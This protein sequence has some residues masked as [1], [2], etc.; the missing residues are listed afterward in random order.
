MNRLNDMLN[1][2]HNQR[3]LEEARKERLAQEARR[4]SRPRRWFRLR[5]KQS[6]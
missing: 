1:A 2:E 4:S 6:E 5:S 3:L